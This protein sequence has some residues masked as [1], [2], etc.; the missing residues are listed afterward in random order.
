MKVNRSEVM[1]SYVEDYYKNSKY[2]SAQN[3][4]KGKELDQIHTI[5]E[6]LPY[7]FNPQTATWGLKLWEELY[8]LKYY[9]EDM[10]ARRNQVLQKMLA[11]TIIT[12][13]SLERFLSK[14]FF[15][16]V[17]IIRNVAPYTFQIQIN[18]EDV[19]FEI[20]KF[21]IIVEEHK[22]AHMAYQLQAKYD[23][24]FEIDIDISLAFVLQSDFYPRYNLKTLLLDGTW[25]L[26]GTYLLNGYQSDQTI[27][28]YP[29]YLTLWSSTN[30]IIWQKMQGQVMGE[31]VFILKQST[32]MTLVSEQSLST[33][34][35]NQLGLQ[36]EW[37]PHI[38]REEKI[39]YHA[40][41]VVEVESS[42]A[43]TGHN[44]N[45]VELLLQN[46]E[47]ELI[48]EVTAM[49]RQESHLTIE[50]DLWFLDGTVLL[51]G[52]RLLDAEIIE[53]QL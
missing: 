20:R 11:V 6:E 52:S 13:I 39:K 15:V 36:V 25:K 46:K 33:Q 26:D 53:Y 16:P 27:D 35:E 45:K 2:Y 40:G 29:L 43:S 37:I 3:N 48:Q 4:A 8:G 44:E 14:V 34:Q 42:S 51:D 10:E 17:H 1:L 24:R 28:F 49:P 5:L 47:L 31:V 50:K 19:I 23:L 21:R 30:P 9:S 32:I 18:Y 41:L 7:Q 12:P 22:E 38:E